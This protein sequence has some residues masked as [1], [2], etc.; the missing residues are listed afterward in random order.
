[1]W[2]FDV[3]E[4]WGSRGRFRKSRS[5]MGRSRRA[6]QKRGADLTFLFVGLFDSH[7]CPPPN[8]WNGWFRTGDAPGE[9]FAKSQD[10][11]GK[12][13][14]GDIRICIGIAGG[15]RNAS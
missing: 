6:V 5:A 2:V 4:I 14:H 1:M 12:A 9:V 11:L 15:T 10:N 3:A 13:R 8:V 7:P